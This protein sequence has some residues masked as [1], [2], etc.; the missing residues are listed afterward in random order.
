MDQNTQLVTGLVS[1]P[2]LTALVEMLKAFVP[3]KRFWPVIAVVMGVGLNIGVSVAAG[4]N[5]L[6]AALQ[7]LAAGLA[8]SGLYSTAKS[9]KDMA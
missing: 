8:A 5:I 6:Q 2:L 7:G 4:G 3:D 9:V 1:V